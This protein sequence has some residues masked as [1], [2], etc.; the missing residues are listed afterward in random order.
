MSAL[1]AAFQMQSTQRR[2]EQSIKRGFPLGEFWIQNDLD[3]VD[4]AL[5][6]AALN[7]KNEADL[8]A[9][10]LLESQSSQLRLWSDWLVQANRKL[11][12]AEYYMSPSTLDNDERFQ[13]T[14][15]CTR[16]LVSMLTSRRLAEDRSCQ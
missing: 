15:A 9:L 4:D 1:T 11:Q 10:R 3:Q 7:V 8:E 13:S 6:L 12:L 14:V 2:L 16:F 5:N